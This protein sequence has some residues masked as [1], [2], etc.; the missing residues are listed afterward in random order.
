M[1]HD[2]V[3]AAVKVHVVDL[4]CLRPLSSRIV[5]GWV[6]AAA[7]VLQIHPHGTCSVIPAQD[8]VVATIAV[9]VA[10]AEPFRA[11][12]GL[13]VDAVPEPSAG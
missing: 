4:E 10:D 2:N 3:G 8:D 11:V 6:E 9:Q 12:K 5:D 1:E 13:I 7:R